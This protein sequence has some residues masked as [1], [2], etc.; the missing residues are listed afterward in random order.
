MEGSLDYEEI[1][2]EEP[3]LIQELQQSSFELVD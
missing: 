3:D 1:V 2:F